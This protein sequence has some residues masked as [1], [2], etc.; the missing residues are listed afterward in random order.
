M[1]IGEIVQ[2]ML[3][4]LVF[5]LPNLSYL[6]CPSDGNEETEEEEGAGREEDEKDVKSGARPRRISELKTPN[7]AKPIPQASSLF[8][9]TPTNK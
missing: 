4:A 8:I 7:K 9:L 2:G 5:V 6:I 3:S 1:W